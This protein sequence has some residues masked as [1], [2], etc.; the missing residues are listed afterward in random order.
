MKI[1]VILGAGRPAA[2]IEE[3]GLLADRYGLGTFW[4]QS[5]PSR[6]EP[7]MMMAGLARSSKRWSA[8]TST[9]WSGSP[10]CSPTTERLLRCL[11]FLLLALPR[12]VAGLPGLLARAVGLHVVGG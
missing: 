6:R 7:L 1:D 2:E 10:A 4:N 9:R 8:N 11:L 5:F 3:L 12:D